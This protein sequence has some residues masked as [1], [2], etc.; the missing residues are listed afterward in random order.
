MVESGHVSG[1][2][3]ITCL[4]LLANKAVGRLS[5]EI[6]VMEIGVMCGRPVFSKDNLAGGGVV[7]SGH[8][9]GLFARY[10]LTAGLDGFRGPGPIQ[11]YALVP[12]DRGA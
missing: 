10:R 7:E 11:V 2:F 9:S 8:V 5:V 1:L 3:A 6:G 12:K 4:K